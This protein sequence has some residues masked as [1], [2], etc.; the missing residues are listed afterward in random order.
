MTSVRTSS[1]ALNLQGRWLVGQFYGRKLQKVRAGE[2]PQQMRRASRLLTCSCVFRKVHRETFAFPNPA[3][4]EVYFSPLIA[5]VRFCKR[6]LYLNCWRF[7]PRFVSS[8]PEKTNKQK[9]N[10]LGTKMEVATKG[11]Y[12][13]CFV[14]VVGL[15]LIWIKAPSI[16][17][18]LFR[19]MLDA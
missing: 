6:M 1:S 11:Q 16:P 12:N 19:G 14:A 17:S 2:Q 5:R 7:T 13:A 4:G 15:W 8:L 9:N 3:W 18:V 10:N